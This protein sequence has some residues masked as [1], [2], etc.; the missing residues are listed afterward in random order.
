MGKFD[1]YCFYDIIPEVEKEHVIVYGEN[2]SDCMEL[3]R[4][5]NPGISTIVYEGTY[6]MSINTPKIITKN[7]WK[8]NLM[9]G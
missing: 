4:L 1:L 6:Y 3:V 9:F 8:K 2:V 7:K 5:K